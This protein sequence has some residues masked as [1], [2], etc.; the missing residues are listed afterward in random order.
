[1]NAGDR[2]ARIDRPTVVVAFIAAGL[3]VAY[4]AVLFLA[5][6]LYASNTPGSSF[7]TAPEGLR[8]YRDYLD[9]LGYE[10]DVL[11]SFDALPDGTIVFAADEPPAQKPT[12]AERERLAGWVR[13]GGR[14]VLAGAYADEILGRTGFGGTVT[15]RGDDEA[16]LQPL[17]PSA[18]VDG[19]SEVRL[20]AGRV[21]ADTP[22]WATLLKD[23][24]GQGL[25]VA[26]VGKGELVR[27]ADSYP[28]TNDGIGEADNA[29]LVTLLA[30]A[31]GGDVYFD[32]YHH[33][34]LAGGGLVDRLGP[35]GRAAVLLAMLATILALVA[36]GRRIGPAVAPYALPAARGTGYIVTLGELYRKAGA[37]ATALEEIEE[38]LR[39]ALA[40][41][42]GTLAAGLARHDTARDA[43]QRAREVREAAGRSTDAAARIRRD[44]FL[45]AAGA[46][47]QARCEVEGTDG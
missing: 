1:M 36:Y 40:R 47:R 21:L 18:Y 14:L 2:R 3:L 25:L 41:R 38:G 45:E 11:Q 30:A 31:G 4:V 26:R 24:D 12:S 34:Y 13:S 23:L 15:Q 37:R 5:R 8:T 46:I 42:H 9:E 28:M 17:S 27:L 22:E 33:G 39:R 20:G 19:V 6:D 10:P 35:G 29:R 44:A 43:L 7:S 16:L 32:E